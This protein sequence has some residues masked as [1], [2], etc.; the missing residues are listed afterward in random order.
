MFSSRVPSDRR[1]NRLALE[2]ARARTAHRLIDL[3][4]S[5]PTRVSISYPDNLL[6]PLSSPDALT[7]RPEPFGL[8]DARAAVAGTY[9]RRGLPIDARQ[10]VLTASTSEAYS[11]LFK[12]L[13]DPGNADVLTPVPSY[14]LFDHLTRL[15]GV[16]QRRYALEYHGCWSVDL[17]DVDR[18]WSARTR[19]VLAV[20]PNN[21]TGSGLTAT[22]A[23]GLVSRCA[24]RSA[25]LIVDEVF[26]DYPLRELKGGRP[27]PG[28]PDCLVFRL[29][30]LS[31]SAGLPQVK[32]GWLTV[33]GPPAL[34]EEALDRL[35]LI[36]DTYLSVATPVQLAA[37]SLI[38]DSAVV[39]HRIHARVRGNLD[40]LH[41]AVA[42]GSGAVTLLEPDG[43][44]SAV[45]RVPSREGEEALVLQLL[46]Q[47]GVVV[48]PGFFFDF[49]REAYL[50]M[51]LLPEPDVFAAGVERILERVDGA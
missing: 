27:V 35:E 16:D 21:P 7:Y 19:A 30:G 38:E 45:L 28:G 51:S 14:P 2:V 13:C 37:R 46:E 10:I 6:A 9:L 26:V 20:A 24:D 39:R 34:V 47:D 44:W 8:P 23:A 18:L 50:V 17:Q 43:G 32:L 12:L 15:E 25:A 33:E 22:E 41:Q 1:P 5:N 42:S 11:L 40:H 3:T 36:C 31:K 29:G 4:V 49:P 48:H